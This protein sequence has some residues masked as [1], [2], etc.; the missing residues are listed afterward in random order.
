MDT[1]RRLARSTAKKTTKKSKKKKKDS[2]SDGEKNVAG[3][4][5]G[6]ITQVISAFQVP[7]PGHDMGAVTFLDIPGHAAFRSMRQSGS[8]AADIIVLVIAADDGISPQTIEILDFYKSLVKGAGGGGISL[9]VAMN[10]IDKPGI[11]VREA[12]MRIENQLLE[13]GIFTEGMGGS[14]DGAHGSPIQL[15]PISGLTGEGVDALIEG[16]TLQSEVMDLR[17][18]DTA[19]AEGYIMDAR[20]EK[21]LGTVVD[22]VI[23]WGSIKTGDFIVSGTHSGKVRILKDVNGQSL[24]KGT[25]SQPVRLTGFDTIPKAGDPIMC[26]SEEEFKEEV[27]KRT[28]AAELVALDDSENSSGH[29]QAEIQSAGKV[30]MKQ[31][32]LEKFKERY[33]MEEKTDDSPIRIPVIIRADADGTLSA[34]RDS[35]FGLAEES[36][37]DV[38]IEPII[39]GVGPLLEADVDLAKDSGATIVCF[40]IGK[41]PAI[42]LAKD[43]GVSILTNDVIYRLL[44]GAR[45]HFGKYLPK[46]PEVTV[47]GRAKVGAVYDIGGLA[48]KVAGLEV[49]EG[50]LFRNQTSP[51]LGQ[52]KCYYRVLRNDHVI[53]RDEKIESTS[54]KHFKEDVTEVVRGKECGLSLDGHN[55]YKNGDVIECYSVEMKNQNL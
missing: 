40:N 38:A 37:H 51:A 28:T 48:T 15:F 16:L 43:Q 6:G 17:A 41:S 32:W 20:V 53:S 1:L 45:E 2:D 23:R 13:Q 12:R 52:H 9:V 22:C 54:L 27:K 33:G 42:R 49:F 19:K 3:T 8:D 18:D 39:T 11:D 55:E 25:P 29:A 31:E 50:T 24:K 35:I 44:E 21:G 4:E 14:N 46:V 10:K 30:M 47:H 5:A 36:D 7:L 34:I 26:L